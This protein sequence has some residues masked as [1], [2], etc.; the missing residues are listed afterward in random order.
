MTL[1]EKIEKGRQYRS[2]VLEV[3][4][5]NEPDSYIVEG[6]ATTYNEPYTLYADD[7]IEIREQVSPTAF[8]GCDMS[9][10]IMQY[11]HQ[12]RVFARTA[13]NTLSLLSDEHGLLINANLGGTTEGRHLYEEIAGGYTNKMSFGFTVTGESIEDSRTEGGKRSYLRTIT[14]IGKL[15]DVSAVS[16]PANDGTEISARSFC[17]GVIAEAEAE[18][19]LEA[20][21]MQQRAKLQLKLKLME[22]N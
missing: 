2:M 20:E 7:E 16:L 6:Y 1:E 3:R 10:V 19:L 12:G 18:R 22:A 4:E 5:Q 9:D 14:Q 21:K 17:D 13:N 8:E 11:D 15:Y